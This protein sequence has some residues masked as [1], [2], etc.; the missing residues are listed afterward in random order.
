MKDESSRKNEPNFRPAA[1]DVEREN[2]CQ[3]S[4]ASECED[5][6]DHAPRLTFPGCQR[7]GGPFRFW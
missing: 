2:S 5:K 4:V 7:L 3:L 6:E 1:R